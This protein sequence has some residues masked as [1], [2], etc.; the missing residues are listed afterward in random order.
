MSRN[1]SRGE[2][3]SSSNCL[4]ILALKQKQVVFVFPV[5]ETA[6]TSTLTLLS[7]YSIPIAS[8][9]EKNR[10][11]PSPNVTAKVKLLTTCYAV[12]VKSKEERDVEFSTL[13]RIKWL[14]CLVRIRDEAQL[15][16]LDRFEQT[17]SISQLV[18]PVDYMTDPTSKFSQSL[19][20]EALSK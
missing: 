12:H 7:D 19:Q 8:Q 20:I 13:L 6:S 9:R 14:T 4:I 18:N 16:L 15:N 10:N 17:T 1:D 11:V 3:L 5:S 2:S